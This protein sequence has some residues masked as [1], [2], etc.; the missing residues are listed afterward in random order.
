MSH[1]ALVLAHQRDDYLRMANTY[2]AMAS[3]KRAS[4][5]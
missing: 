4:T 3:G 1:A 5:E 2:H